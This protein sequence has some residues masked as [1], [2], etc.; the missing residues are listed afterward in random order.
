VFALLA[1]AAVIPRHP[2]DGI[3]VAAYS[4]VL[5]LCAVLAARRPALA[6]AVLIAIDAFD[7]YR[8][9]GPTTLTLPKM[10]LIGTIAGLCV[11]RPS[12]RVLSERATL[13]LLLGGALLVATT[14]L[15]ITQAAYPLEAVRQTIKAIEFLVLFATVVV[16]MRSD[17]SEH[18][19]RIALALTVAVVS[20]LAISQEFGFA[21]SV[22]PYAGG[23][24]P[25]IAGP[26]EGPNQLS[27]Y[28]GITLPMIAAFT[29][30][31][32]PFRSELAA[33]AL[34]VFALI[35]TYS[36]AGI[37]A[38]LL[39]LALVMA[40]A[41][42]AR[43]RALAMLTSAAVFAGLATL[44]AAAKGISVL[45]HFGMMSNDY[46]AGGVGNRS[47]LWHAA[48]ALW[49]QHP[50]LG[51]GAGN[52][53]FEI[54]RVGPQG[55]KTHANSLYLQALVEGGIPMLAAQ[56]YMTAASILA[57]ARRSLGEP[58]LLGVCVGSAC[59]ALHQVLDFLVFYVKVGGMWWI[60]LGLAAARLG[61]IE[62]TCT[63]TR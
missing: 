56:L 58:L 11:R 16:A 14:A 60:S 3:A 29:L 41:P 6:V 63:K 43:R 22:L 4:G 10:A 12:L 42:S 28:Y 46:G 9:I 20:A 26:L 37:V 55:V 50:W 25:R 35:L 19:V 32:A 51:I 44:V 13:A 30:L 18:C 1:V 15:S 24:L 39:A 54:G 33:L 23:L 62:N 53:E 36:R 31:R 8:D 47:A 61:T 45:W 38:T 21:P 2:L 40:L 34:G 17:P 52:F 59:L 7:L 48:I 57:F 27:G 5:L 49:R